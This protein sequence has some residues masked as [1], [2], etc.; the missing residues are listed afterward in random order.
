M[1]P[2]VAIHPPATSCE[3]LARRIFRQVMSPRARL[4]RCAVI[5]REPGERVDD[6]DQLLDQLGANDSVQLTRLECGAV[7]LAWTNQHAGW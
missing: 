3:L 1:P 2:N 6:W 7:R 5:V 4:Q